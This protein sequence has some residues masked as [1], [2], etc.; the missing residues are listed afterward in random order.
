MGICMCMGMAHTSD[1]SGVGVFIVPPHGVAV[2]EWAAA[3]AEW[4]PAPLLTADQADAAEPS[5]LRGLLSAEDIEAL[6]GLATRLDA[7]RRGPDAQDEAA[8]AGAAAGA[9]G[10]AA[11]GAAAGTTAGAVG[12]AGGGSED[13]FSGFSLFGGEGEADGEDDPW[14]AAEEAWRADPNPHPD[15]NPPTPTPTPTPTRS[16]SL[17]RP[18]MRTGSTA[19]STCTATTPSRGQ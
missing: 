2:S 18:G 13:V 17:S 11:A 15:P 5:V 1:A 6:E 19:S 3:D 16:L 8:T 14:A 9:T 12:A 10:A 4:P 7:E